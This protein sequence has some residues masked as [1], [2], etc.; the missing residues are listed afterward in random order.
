MSHYYRISELRKREI[1]LRSGLDSPGKTGG[2]F[3]RDRPR[4]MREKGGSSNFVLW[5]SGARRGL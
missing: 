5:H 1:F 2:G 3:S 4:R